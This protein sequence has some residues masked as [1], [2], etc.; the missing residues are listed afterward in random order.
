MAKIPLLEYL[1]LKIKMIASVLMVFV[2][3]CKFVVVHFNKDRCTYIAAALTFTSLLSLVPLMTV[4]FAILRAFPAFQDLSTTVND[5]IFSNF[6]PA[7]SDVIQEHIESFVTQA[8]SLTLVGSI[9]LL[10][11]ALMTMSTIEQAFNYIWRVKYRRRGVATF[12][13][14]WAILTMAP[15]L[16]G[17]SLVV[18]SYLTTLPFVS[19][20]ATTI[21]FK[22]QLLMVMP[23]ILTTIAFTLLYMAIPNRRIRFKH[24][25]VG[26]I[27]AA[28]LF[29]VTKRGFAFYVQAFPTYELLYGTL[30]TIPIFLVWVYLSWLIILLGAE[31]ANSLRFDHHRHMGHK[32]A[33]NLVVAFYW[34]GF[35]YQAQQRG[36]GLSLTKL[37][38]LY[39]GQHHVDADELMTQLT[40]AK[41]IRQLNNGRYILLRDLSHFTL[42]DL[43]HV[44]E[45]KLPGVQQLETCQ[46]EWGQRL[47]PVF[48]STDRI[49]QQELGKPLDQFYQE[50]LQH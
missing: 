45:W 33:H 18:T 24:A 39:G 35:L 15:M 27:F 43:Y 10:I 1:T 19:E 17:I 23:F 49:I 22:T 25:F 37:I 9:F 26:G 20:T 41:L 3:Y 5:F 12:L 8:S 34:L 16:I 48:K 29:E 44:L 32:A 7:S 40:D 21:G 11:T 42:E 28:V 36:D 14:Y 13:T 2:R 47:L 30:A 31:I 38:R 50:P 6:V 46:D 4:G